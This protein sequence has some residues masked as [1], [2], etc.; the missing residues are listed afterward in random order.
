MTLVA[1]TRFLLVYTF[2]ADQEE[3]ERIR[4]L[5]RRSLREQLVIP[6]VVV[7]E[8]FKTAGRKIGKQGVTN[9]ISVLKDN[10]AR[11]FAVDE[12]TALLAGEILLKDEK[13]SIG[14]ALIAAAALILH[15]S[16]IVTDDPHFHE[17]DLKTR[18]I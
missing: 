3:R 7:T 2:P 4:E 8:Y 13:R 10:G 14:D 1:D 12:S 16:Y 6:A 9:Q 11:I 5:M 15:A 18:W 17:F